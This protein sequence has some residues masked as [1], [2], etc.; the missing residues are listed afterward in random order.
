[1]WF[2]SSTPPEPTRSIV[3]TDA[4]WLSSTGGE[5]LTSAWT[6]WCSLTQNR[7]K[8]SGSIRRAGN[9]AGPSWRTGADAGSTGD[10]PQ[11]ASAGMSATRW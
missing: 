3:V 2:G 8:P 7:R 9:S 5:V 6:P 11:L 10:R 4:M 1:V